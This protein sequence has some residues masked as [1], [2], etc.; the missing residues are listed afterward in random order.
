MKHLTTDQLLAFE[1]NELSDKERV[2]LENHLKE[3]ETCQNEL[4]LLQE[5]HNEWL[6]PSDVQLP[7]NVIDEIMMKTEKIESYPNKE[8]KSSPKVNS[9]AVRF[10]HLL[11]AAAATFLFFQL[12]FTKYITNSNH[13]VVQTIDQT[14]SLLN[15]SEKITFHFPTFWNKK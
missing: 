14:S 6:H 13:Q 2:F 3:C 1:Q 4:A 10:V 5:L 7:F 9:R 15:K 8:K 12:Q 11:I